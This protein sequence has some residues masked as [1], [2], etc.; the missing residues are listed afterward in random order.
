MCTHALSSRYSF[1]S[2]SPALFF[3][4]CNLI[5]EAEKLRRLKKYWKMSQQRDLL[6][7]LLLFPCLFLSGVGVDLFG[8]LFHSF[9]LW[10][11]A[12]SQERKLLSK[13]TGQVHQNSCIICPQSF[14]QP[15]YT[16][17]PWNALCCR[18]YCCWL[19]IC[20]PCAV[21]FGVR[22]LVRL[23]HMTLW[24]PSVLATHKGLFFFFYF[25]CWLSVLL[26][27]TYNRNH[28]VTGSFEILLVTF[29]FLCPCSKR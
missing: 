13:E 27:W 10:A 8:T 20:F 11:G 5:L 22:E 16:F 2:Q 12:F 14:G 21:Y 15:K 24:I 18:C 6:W 9:S 23:Y 4:W 7:L 17:L 28:E 1:K 25:S 3:S 29:P 26:L 19:I